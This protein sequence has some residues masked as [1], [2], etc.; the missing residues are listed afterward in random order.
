MK[1]FTSLSSSRLAK[2]SK[3]YSKLCSYKT[4]LNKDNIPRLLESVSWLSAVKLAVIPNRHFAYD[5][6]NIVVKLIFIDIYSI[7][8][9]DV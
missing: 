3:P 4:I 6:T 1:S 5:D 7:I 8:I 2:Y 9:P